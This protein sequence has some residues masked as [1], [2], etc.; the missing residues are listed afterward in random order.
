MDAADLARWS[1]FAMKG[2]IG[3]CTALQDCVAKAPEDLMFVK[4]DGI[5]VLKQLSGN[6]WYLGY[7]AGIVGRFRAKA[8]QFHSKLKTSVSQE[9]AGAYFDHSGITPFASPA[10]SRPR[11]PTVTGSND[12]SPN[13]EGNDVPPWPLIFWTAFRITAGNKADLPSFFRLLDG[14]NKDLFAWDDRDT[15]EVDVDV[16]KIYPGQSWLYPRAWKQFMAEIDSLTWSKILNLTR[17]VSRPRHGS[18]NDLKIRLAALLIVYSS[19][20]E[21]LH[22]VLAPFNINFNQPPFS[23]IMQVIDAG[24]RKHSTPIP[25]DSKDFWTSPKLK[26]WLFASNQDLCHTVWHASTPWSQPSVLQRVESMYLIL[27]TTLM[28]QASI[29]HV[30]AIP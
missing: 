20:A 22:D 12:S 18:T 10:S 23:S 19:A 3:K 8:V 16:L 26:D 2:G 5:V 7:C 17:T 11:T 28:P 25:P 4:G 14:P 9:E 27:T 24:Y 1:R 30:S 6:G 29:S 21:D 15:L 13:L